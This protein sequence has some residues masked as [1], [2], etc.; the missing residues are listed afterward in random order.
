MVCFHSIQLAG[1]CQD[2]L[3]FGMYSWRSYQMIFVGLEN[4]QGVG[5]M[6]ACECFWGAGSSSVMLTL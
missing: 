2:H 6:A 4:R 5:A 1:P 3:R